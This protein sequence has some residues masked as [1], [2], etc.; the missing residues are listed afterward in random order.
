MSVF[1]R[2]GLNFMGLISDIVPD[3]D[4]HGYGEYL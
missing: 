3:E 4:G 1:L 2:I